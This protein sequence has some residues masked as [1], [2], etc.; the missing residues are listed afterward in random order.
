MSPSK[1]ECLFLERR[2]LSLSSVE[3][4]LFGSRIDLTTAVNNSSM[5]RSVHYVIP[6]MYSFDLIIWIEVSWGETRKE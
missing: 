1:E 6:S 5:E 2:S 3:Q 4:G